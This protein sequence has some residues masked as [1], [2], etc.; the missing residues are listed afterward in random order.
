[1]GM[2]IDGRWTTDEVSLTDP[3]GRWQR[4]PSTLR[5]WVTASGRPGSA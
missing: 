5:N 1:M 2:L 4:A 3:A